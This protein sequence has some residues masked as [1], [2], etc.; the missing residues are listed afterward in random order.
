MEFFNNSVFFGV[1]LSLLAYG[2]GA[3]LK[4]KFK[5]A[6]FN[7]LL[8]AVIIVIAVL[9]V[10]GIDYKVYNEGAKYISY[11]LTPATICLAIPLYEQFELLKSNWKAIAVGIFSGVLAS[12][13]SILAMAVLFGFTHQEYVSFLPKSITTAIGMGISEELGGYV[14]ITVAI[15]VLTGVLGNIC[16]ES[17]CKLF[18]IEEPIAKGIA[19]GTA[20]HAIGTSKAMELGD[21]EGAM[22]SLSIVVSGLIT[23]IGA[24]KLFTEVYS[25]TVGGPGNA[26]QVLGLFLYQNAFLHDDMGMAAA[27]G[28]L[29]FVIT[30]TASIFQLKVSRSGEI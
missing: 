14:S 8:I 19:I 24:F 30:V 5:L 20:S 13:G 1:M 15:I 9:A 18:K 27:T 21:I 11:L 3:L 22:S 28:V 10:S 2:I 12:L 4:Q 26:S 7:P 17:V 6:I 29:I 25:T 23:V 16:A